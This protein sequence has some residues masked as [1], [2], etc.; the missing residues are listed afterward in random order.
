M[1]N[2]MGFW[3]KQLLAHQRRHVG[4]VTAAERSLSR[5]NKVFRAALAEPLVPWLREELASEWDAEVERV[6]VSFSAL[7]RGKSGSDKIQA[8]KDEAFDKAYPTLSAFLCATVDENGKSRI[9]S[10]LNFFVENGTCKAGLRE[11]NA[12]LSLWVSAPGILEV[13]GALEIALTQPVID[14]RVSQVDGSSRRA[15]RSS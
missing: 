13:F 12:G 14:W 8:F 15:G 6:M 5:I 2:L 7:T 4:D 1:E 11:R 10:T 3:K 9:T